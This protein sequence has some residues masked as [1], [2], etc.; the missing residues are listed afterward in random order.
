[1]TNP[2]LAH[3]RD[4]NALY[5]RFS[6]NTIV[7]TVELWD[8][9][10]VDVDANG[11]SVGFEKLHAAS[12]DL[13]GFPALPETAALR[14]LLNPHTVWSAKNFAETGRLWSF[15]AS[16]HM[17]IWRHA[18]S[19]RTAQSLHIETSEHPVVTS[20]PRRRIYP[21]RRGWKRSTSSAGAAPS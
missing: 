8:S 5:I 2:T 4:A 17:G 13:T 20:S 14:D 1:M 9:V 12:A 19:R 15:C 7:K 3:D 11:E 21:C 16:N 10:Y 6:T 18:D